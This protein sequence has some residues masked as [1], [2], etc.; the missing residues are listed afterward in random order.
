MGACHDVNRL[1][2]LFVRWNSPPH[3]H[4]KLP[5]RVLTSVAGH[6]VCRKTQLGSRTRKP[7][8]CRHRQFAGCHRSTLPP[9]LGNRRPV[10]RSLP[11]SFQRASADSPPR[12]C[13]ISSQRCLSNLGHDRQSFLLTSRADSDRTRSPSHCQRPLPTR[14]AS[15]ISRDV[16]FG[17]LQRS[18][19]RLLA[20]VGS[21]LRLCLCDT[22]KNL[23]RRQ[24]SQEQPA[25][26]H[27]LRVS[28]SVGTS[29][30]V[31]TQKEDSCRTYNINP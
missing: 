12:P 30:S 2:T 31:G 5:C 23:L 6:H 15:R 16:N 25:G 29:C 22:P 24:I 4:P 21:C 27:R 3:L 7:Q 19:H 9:Y 18:R 28:R 14:A 8:R 1:A 13:H 26:V 20:G 10:G 17:S 11:H